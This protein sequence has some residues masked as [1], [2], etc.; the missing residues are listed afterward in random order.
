[1]DDSWFITYRVHP[2]GDVMAYTMIG[3]GEVDSIAE[4]I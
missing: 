3:R 2:N 1:M 4:D